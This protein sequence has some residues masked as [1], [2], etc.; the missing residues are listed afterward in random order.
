MNSMNNKKR[1]LLSFIMAVFLLITFPAFA[2]AMQYGVAAGNY[3][4]GE[5]AYGTYGYN[6]VQSNIP[7]I[8][9]GHVSS[10]YVLDPPITNHREVGWVKLVDW[11]NPKFFAAWTDNGIY[12]QQLFNDASPNSNHSYKV[13]NILGTKDWQFYVD[14]TLKLSK[15]N[16]TQTW[17]HGI[18]VCSSERN[19]L[20]DT[21]YSHFWSL[22][23]MNSN[24]TLY[25]W[26]D[27]RPGTDNDPEYYL[28]KYSDT[29]C[30]MVKES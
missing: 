21:N 10:I 24:G 23:Y 5:N 12:G 27:L 30:Y 28:E 3:S 6:Y 25:S 13:Q 22:K 14:G 7:T 8:T 2:V 18:S 4:S 17:T 26:T 20:G 9:S 19:D 11:E 16:F 15:T 1:I 29:E